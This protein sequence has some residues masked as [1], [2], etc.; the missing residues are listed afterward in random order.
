MV[1]SFLLL[2]IAR[3]GDQLRGIKKGILELADASSR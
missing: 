2:T 3:T 1:D